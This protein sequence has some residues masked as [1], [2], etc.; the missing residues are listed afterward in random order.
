MNQIAKDIIFMKDNYKD[1]K[2]TTYNSLFQRDKDKLKGKEKKQ[3]NTVKGKYIIEMFVLLFVGMVCAFFFPYGFDI[4]DLDLELLLKSMKLCLVFTLASLPLTYKDSEQYTVSAIITTILINIAILGEMFD[5]FS[6]VIKCSIIVGILVSFVIRIWCY[7]SDNKRYEIIPEEQED[8]TTKKIY[9]ICKKYSLSREDIREDIG[10]MIWGHRIDHSYYRIDQKLPYPVTQLNEDINING[11]NLLK[12]GLESKTTKN[13]IQNITG[14]DY[15]KVMLLL[16]S[17]KENLYVQNSIREIYLEV[18]H[19]LEKTKPI[20]F[21]IKNVFGLDKPILKR[22]YYN[23]YNQEW[24]E[25]HFDVPCFQESV[26]SILVSEEFQRLVRLNEMYQKKLQEFESDLKG[27]VIG[28]QGERQ[29][30]ESLNDFAEIIGKNKMKILS[31]VRFEQNG[32]TLESDF[33]VV[34]PNGVFALEVKNL[35]STG[36]YNVTVEKDGLWKKVMKNGRWKQMPDSISRQN[37]RHLMGIEQIINSKLNSST[38]NW[39][40]A[41]SLIVFANNVVGIRNYS[42]NV[43]IRDSEIM[44]EIRK[45]PICF[46]EKQIKEIAD[47]LQSENLPAKEYKMENWAKKFLSLHYEIAERAQNLLPIIQPYIDI[48]TA[49]TYK[50]YTEIPFPKYQQKAD[51]ITLAD[52]ESEYHKSDEEI[53]QDKAEEQIRRQNEK[54]TRERQE[55]ED[56]NSDYQSEEDRM[57]HEY[58]IGYQGG[59]YNMFTVDDDR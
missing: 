10:G 6:L 23:K 41:K 50:E 34:C 52:D 8:E 36:S 27:T 49:Y 33:I 46:N 22:R 25:Y 18:I 55:E 2:V 32:K 19:A 17:D 47:I 24:V 9:E 39:I 58:M 29:V 38:E 21:D 20:C 45:N 7:L 56:Y 54:E 3:W 14:K 42:N 40:S 53:A 44:T 16:K 26:H 11:K 57:W 30:L 43:I 31:N 4:T 13:I 51:M 59:G 28:A 35:G 12:N 1:M 37:E 48:M 15:E 5:S